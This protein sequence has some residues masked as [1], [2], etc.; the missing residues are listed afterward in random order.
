[1]CFTIFSVCSISEW[2]ARMVGLFIEIDLYKMFYVNLRDCMCV[3]QLLQTS[4]Y[5]ENFKEYFRSKIR[6]LI[7]WKVCTQIATIYYILE[8]ELLWLKIA[9]SFWISISRGPYIV[10]LQNIFAIR[11]SFLLI[12]CISHD[13]YGISIK[14]VSIV[15]SG[16]VQQ[17]AK[18]TK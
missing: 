14:C 8:S 12:V 18:C 13:T 11:S 17:T 16:W 15:Y 2:I 10:C 1:M 5:Q 3:I 4:V 6:V 9:K 7:K